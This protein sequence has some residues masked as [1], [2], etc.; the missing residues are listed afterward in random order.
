M[1]K[2][3]D[4][5]IMITITQPRLLSVSDEEET[6][7]RS[8]NPDRHFLYTP[9]MVIASNN[10]IIISHDIGG[11]I[12]DIE[13]YKPFPFSAQ[14]MLCQLHVRNKSD[15]NFRTVH[16]YNMCHGRLFKIKER[17]YILGHNGRLQLGYSDDNGNTWSQMC[18]LGS[19]LDGWHAS[20]CNV[21]IANERLYLCM[22]RRENKQFLDW[23][24]A[25]LTPHILSASIK[26]DLTNQE[27]WKISHSFTFCD[28]FQKAQF[29][30]FGLPFLSTGYRWAARSIV[31]KNTVKSSPMGWL[32]GNIVQIYDRDHFWY[33]PEF[34][35]FYLFLRCN[36]AGVGYGAVLKV[37]EDLDGEM[38]TDLIRAPS[39]EPLVFLPLPGGHNKFFIQYDC[40]SKHYWMAATQP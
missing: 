21:L 9:S 34:R 31:N 40:P 16:H 7:I 10:A 23:N 24:V 27:S 17:I 11:E 2:A 15:K 22:E 13:Q 25:G 12:S 6:A 39:G 38:Y 33:D 8:G 26:A 1:Q 3:L 14:K 28:L 36:T 30:Y 20:A 19:G 37:I 35:T 5:I 18:E 29:P 4:K 32:E